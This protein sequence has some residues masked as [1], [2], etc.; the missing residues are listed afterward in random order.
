MKGYAG[1]VSHVDLSTGK[2]WNEKFDE[3][4][5]RKYLGG[6]GFAAR[7]LIASVPGGA[8]PLGEE[9]VLIFCTGPLNGTLAHGSGRAG[10]VT[11]SPLTG[12]FMDSYFGGD[13]GAQLKQSGRDMLVISGK[14]PHPVVLYC[15]DDNVHLIPSE[16]LWGLTTLQVQNRLK[17]K[18]G[19]D[20]RSVCCGP[21][22]EQQVPMACCISGRRAAGRGGTGAVMGSKHLKAVAVPGSRDIAGHVPRPHHHINAGRFDTPRP[23]S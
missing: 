13:W 2:V 23:L 16:D 18:L 4:Y 6:N 15:D 22:G 8:D 21:A 11:K 3:A 14:S 20:I 12:Y 10:I 19:N 17:Q 7:T 5:A 9:N 1:Q